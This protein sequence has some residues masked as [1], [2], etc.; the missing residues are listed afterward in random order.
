M[1]KEILTEEALPTSGAKKT[2][3]EEAEAGE[4][5]VYEVS[6]LLLPFITE[7]DISKEA[8]RIKELVSVSGGAVFSEELPKLMKLAYTMSKVIANKNTKFDNAYFGWM[9]FEGEPETIAKLKKAF[10]NNENVLRFL[11]L[12]T[13]KDV[14]STR[15]PFPFT[16]KPVA[17]SAPVAPKEEVKPEVFEDIDEVELD[18]T[19]DDL[20]IN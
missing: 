4:L 8:L 18:K 10:E 1:E 2:Q 6:Y 13:T 15:K 12:K 3:K 11:V 16:A 9:K 19:I 20:V 5:R 17:K 14:V 7:D